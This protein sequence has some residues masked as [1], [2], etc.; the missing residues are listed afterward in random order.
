M[1][2]QNAFTLIELLAVI[3][4]LAII[5]VIAT[6]LTINVI[7][8]AKQKSFINS[9]YGLIDGVRLLSAEQLFQDGSNEVT[10]NF[11]DGTSDNANFK[12]S[13]DLP[14]SGTVYMN[15][16]GKIAL[17]VW[18][19]ELGRCA[20]KAFSSA[21]VIITNT[22]KEDCK[23]MSV[24]ETQTF[25]E[26]MTDNPDVAA[27]DPDQNLRYIGADPSN[28]VWFNNELWRVIG[29][30]DGKTKIIKD[31]YYNDGNYIAFDKGEAD[32]GTHGRWGYNDWAQATLMSELNGTYLSSMQTN[33][34]IS[35][36][37]IDL[38]HVWNL[39]SANDSDSYP[40]SL[41]RSDYYHGERSENISPTTLSH[42]WTGAIGLMYPSDYGY[43]TSGDATLC[44]EKII[45]YW[46]Q[47]NNKTEC[48]G[49]SWLYSNHSQWTIT[50]FL[51]S[52]Y[53]GN[54][55]VTTL[56]SST[57]QIN[58]YATCSAKPVLYL[59]ENVKI[60]RGTGDL[61]DPYILSTGDNNQE[62]IFWGRPAKTTHPEQRVV[63]E[64]DSIMPIGNVLSNIVYK[65]NGV[66]VES[67]NN[68]QIILDQEGE[69]TVEAIATDSEGNIK[70]FKSGIY[71][72][73]TTSPTLTFE[74]GDTAGITVNDV[75]S[76]EILKEGV[77]VTDNYDISL[78]DVIIENLQKESGEYNLVYKATDQAGNIATKTRKVTLNC[79]TATIMGKTVTCQTMTNDPD[80]NIRYVGSTPDNYVSFNGELWRI[81]GVF[82][83][84]AKIIRNA[85][86]KTRIAWDDDSDGSYSNNWATAS[87]QLALNNT[88]DGYIKTI[89]TNDPTSYNYIDLNHVWNIGATSHSSI[90]R[91]EFYTAERS[92]T[93]AKAE[94]SLATWT[95]A[96][97]LISP[98][99][100]GYAS[101]GDATTCNDAKM[102][103]WY[104]GTGKTEC[105]EK[106]WLYNSSYN[107]WTLTPRSIYSD[108]PFFV[109]SNGSISRNSVYLTLATS[110]VLFL[111]SDT[112]IVGGL[113]TDQQPFI[114]GAGE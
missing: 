109:S 30:F 41:S 19:E 8:S 17:K 35:Y 98:S 91:S 69:Y 78:D 44:N 67:V 66:E 84:Q 70:T 65:V 94:G 64:I 89:Q 34:P 21:E 59:K 55:S 74:E 68:K 27:L 80:G 60:M 105:A 24:T 6:P 5:A 14:D 85:Y 26:V 37:Y 1:K 114:L 106:S 46:N 18:S 81:I 104:Y 49:N 96:I 112:K 10:I 16:E 15:S 28:Y 62:L 102:A 100:Y 72:I 99:D 103:N 58:A 11:T 40:S 73:D 20:E 12:V 25:T 38:E 2:K 63:I 54:S 111:K 22:S 7:N 86:Y 36:S 53:G 92:E 83:G 75:A 13:G 71:Q 61:E 77:S 4:I 31:G 51:T 79:S 42:L 23:I 50:P 32:G 45:Y 48:A 52:M 95:G 33:E 93:P 43:S 29:V 39:G 90:T 110:P 107:E 82:N 3:V 9:V 113:G 76:L 108:D 101:S 97:G 87:L 47:G 88:T 57:D 56:S